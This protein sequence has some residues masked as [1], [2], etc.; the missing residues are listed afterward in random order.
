M[1][2]I[3]SKPAAQALSEPYCPFNRAYVTPS[4]LRNHASLKEMHVDLVDKA[5]SYKYGAQQV[6]RDRGGRPGRQ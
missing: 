1:A 4:C 2:R 3:L 5:V 6:P